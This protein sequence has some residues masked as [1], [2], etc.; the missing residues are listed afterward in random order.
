MLVCPSARSSEHSKSMN[1]TS[2]INMSRNSNYGAVTSV[3][4]SRLLEESLSVSLASEQIGS[5]E[6][7]FLRSVE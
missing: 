5:Y 1:D 6:L 2:K 7:L 4:T 3:E